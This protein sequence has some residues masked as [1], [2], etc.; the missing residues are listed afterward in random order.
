MSSKKLV[1][2]VRAGLAG[3]IK[4]IR[5]E[6][7]LI[8]DFVCGRLKWE[9]SK[10]SRM[11]RGQQCISQADLASLLVI[12]E[13]TGQE[14]QRLLRRTERQ[15]D[16]GYWE[17]DTPETVESRTLVR[18]ESDALAIVDV[19]P[20][21]IPELA[22][23]AEYAC[24]LL[25]SQDVPAAQAELRVQARIARQTVLT[26]N[27]PPKFSMILAEQ[28]LRWMVGDRAAMAGQLRALLEM[29]ERPNVR[30]WVVPFDMG[31]NAGMDREFRKMDF[32]NG[33]QVVFWGRESPPFSST[34]PDEQNPFDA[35]LHD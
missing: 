4:H 15:D 6:R 24:A 30:L 16:P 33:E 19:E 27:H 28:V 1:T 17:H 22:Q 34:T 11:E 18:L 26:K 9:Q 20:V 10:V 5:T 25:R 3:E 29:A 35:T 31:G 13:V 14:R 8:L 12:Y 32:P 2:V 23:T 7:G 21:L